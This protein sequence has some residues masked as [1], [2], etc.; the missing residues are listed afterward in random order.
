MNGI[1]TAFDNPKSWHGKSD[2]SFIVL[3][4]AFHARKNLCSPKG[5]INQ[6]LWET[7]KI[8]VA[9]RGISEKIKG[10]LE[11]E[12]KFETAVSL[13]TEE[14]I[15]FASFALTNKKKSGGNFMQFQSL[16]FSVQLFFSEKSFIF[17]E[18]FSAHPDTVISTNKYKM[19]DQETPSSAEHQSV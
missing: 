10:M 3:E 12:K 4:L 9:H 15:R 18:Q 17:S 7:R 6:R 19:A 2:T 1:G 5:C 16:T 14:W 11:E 8:P 13:N